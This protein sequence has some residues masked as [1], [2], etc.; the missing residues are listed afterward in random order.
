VP[1]TKQ[2]ANAPAIP[3]AF[4]PGG[5]LLVISGPSGAGKGSLVDRLVEARPECVFSISAT[6]RPRRSG[7]ENGVQYQFVERDEFVRLRD[8]GEFLEWAEV[9]GQFYGTP[10]K[11]VDEHVRAGRVVLLDVDVQGGASVRRLRPGAVFVFVYPPSIAALR[12]RLVGRNTDT[13]EVVERRLANA[14]GE[15][16]QYRDYDYLII[17]DDLDSASKRLISIVDVERARVPRLRATL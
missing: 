17:N 13:P 8:A 7:E 2:K 5:F 16:A 6:T 1:R 9:H 3:F 10:A 11:F 4:E 15:L 14:P 12:E